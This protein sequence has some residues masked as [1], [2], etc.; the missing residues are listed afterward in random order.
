MIRNWDQLWLVSEMPS[1]KL[2]SIRATDKAHLLAPACP[3]IRCFDWVICLDS[4]RA[5]VLG[6]G[7]TRAVLPGCSLALLE[8]G[9][10]YGEEGVETTH[11]G[12][13]QQL[14]IFQVLTTANGAPCLS[15]KPL[16]NP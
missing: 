12:L 1:A 7:L 14:T 15:G 6:L 11:I 16:S 8:D 3:I 2:L 9:D 13:R 5:V 10:H 4:A